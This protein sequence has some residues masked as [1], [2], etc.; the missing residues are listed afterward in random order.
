MD[1]G[2][3]HLSMVPVR[4]WCSLSTASRDIFKVS[5]YASK[6]LQDVI[7]VAIYEFNPDIFLGV[8]SRVPIFINVSPVL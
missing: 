7:F 2:L 1:F 8:T 3:V 6:G 5:N 4:E